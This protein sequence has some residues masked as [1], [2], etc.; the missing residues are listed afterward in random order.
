[1]TIAYATSQNF[2]DSVAHDLVLLAF[3]S[4]WCEPC[5]MMHSVLKKIDS[6][7]SDTIN[8]VIIDLEENQ[9]IAKS[10]DIIGT[11]TLILFKK[12]ETLGKVTGYQPKEMITD[13]IRKYI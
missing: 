9:D 13:F 7:M 4:T 8:I 12:G 11:P 1:M 6:E 5:K 2:L 10:F 3:S